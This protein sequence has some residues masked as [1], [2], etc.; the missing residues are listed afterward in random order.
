MST[1]TRHGFEEGSFVTFQGVKGMTEVNGQE[2]KIAVP[3]TS[4][5]LEEG[6]DETRSLLG[7]FTFTIGDTTQFNL[8]EGGG[9]VTEVKKPEVI[10]FVSSIAQPSVSLGSRPSSLLEILFRLLGRT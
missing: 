4:F 9:T 3:S 2:F 10:H 1:D 6:I 8:Y 7:P 5:L